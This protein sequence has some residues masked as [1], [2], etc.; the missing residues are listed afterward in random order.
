VRQE[1]L[2]RLK[3]IISG[4]KTN[5]IE[6]DISKSILIKGNKIKALTALTALY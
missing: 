1:M 4:M 5:E 3:G 6:N 2:S